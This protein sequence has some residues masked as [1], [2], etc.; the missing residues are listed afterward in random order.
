MATDT[1]RIDWLEKRASRVDE[2]GGVC[3]YFSLP[4]LPG[5][6]PTPWAKKHGGTYDNKSVREAIDFAMNKEKQRGY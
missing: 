1:E 3:G 4:A 2:G 5:W 6:D